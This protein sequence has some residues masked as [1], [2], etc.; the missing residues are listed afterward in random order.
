MAGLSVLSGT[1]G[2]WLD[3]RTEWLARDSASFSALGGDRGWWQA[4]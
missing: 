2:V 3:A 1:A 4:S